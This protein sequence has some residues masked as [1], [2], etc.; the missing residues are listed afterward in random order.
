VVSSFESE[1]ILP[2]GEVGVRDPFSPTTTAATAL[3]GSYTA[4]LLTDC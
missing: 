2:A 4:S 1:E 3:V